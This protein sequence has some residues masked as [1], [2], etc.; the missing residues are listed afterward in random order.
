MRNR[1][2]P[3]LAAALLLVCPHR[4][5]PAEAAKT[6]RLLTVGN[7]F[8][9]NAMHYLGQLAKADGNTLELHEADIGGSSMEVHWL[10]VQQHE[11]DPQDP[12]G[13][14][15]TG[16]SLQ[17]ELTGN[18]LDFVTIQ[19]A[20]IKS[21]DLA[22][23][24]PFA[25]DLRDYIKKYAP[26]A[27]LLL[28]ETWEYRRDDPRFAHTKPTPGEPPTQDAMYDELSS[29]YSTVARE[30]GVRRIPVGDAF[31]LADN[32]SKWGFHP[33]TTFDPKSAVS[34][35]LPDQTHSLHKGWQWKA[36]KDGRTALTMDGH[37]ASTA[38]EYL[39]GCVFYE[40]LFGANVLNNTF[41]P[42]GLDADYAKF[43][44][45]T[46]HRAVAASLAK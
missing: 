11:K 45:E 42:P 20:S 2:L 3:L 40:V 21:H 39:G 1:A 19:Q 26:A 8:S 43:L 5:L 15:A 9:Q 46:A 24:H 16:R 36:G 22:S 6:V 14:Y 10:K 37:H 23:Y 28:H 13:K 30:L 27:E 17:D 4:A 31:H 12:Q 29:A 41:V 7:S 44:R 25:A 32:D 18:K 34:P 33:D 35:A 38:G